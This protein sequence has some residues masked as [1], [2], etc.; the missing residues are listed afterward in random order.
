MKILITILCCFYFSPLL[1]AQTPPGSDVF[2]LTF[3]SGSRAVESV[4]NISEF[5][6]YD[7]QPAFTPDDSAIIW[8]SIRDSIQADVF[9]FNLNT[10]KTMQLTQTEESEYSPTPLQVN[11]LVFTTVRVEKDGTQRLWQYSEKTKLF[12]LLLPDIKPVGYHTW[13]DSQNLALFVLGEPHALFLV[14]KK[15]GKQFKVAGNIG[16]CLQKIP[17]QNA[18]SFVQKSAGSDWHINAVNMHDRVISKVA[19]VLPGREDYVWFDNSSLLM[20]QGAK[21]YKM[22]LSAEK[23]WMEFLNLQEYGVDSIN[24]MALSKNRKY[25]AFVANDGD[26]KKK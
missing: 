4:K 26:V 18:I 15:N 25:L 1:A 2:L 21:I 22:D 9:S 3:E 13:V 19:R 17:G 12:N 24:R 5:P 10:R 6:G 14:D 11:P 7:N 23:M 20:A 8:A 16:R